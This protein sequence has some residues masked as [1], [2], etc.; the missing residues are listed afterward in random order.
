MDRM[1][2]FERRFSI[3]SREMK[4]TSDHDELLGLVKERKKLD[5][6]YL[7]WIVKR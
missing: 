1:A 3:L 6:D 7:K 2:S 4:K 5:E